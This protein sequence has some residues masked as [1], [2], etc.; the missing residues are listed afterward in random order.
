MPP[1]LREREAELS[2]VR[3]QL[4]AACA[5]NEKLDGAC[6]ELRGQLVLSHTQATDATQAVLVS[7]HAAEE[8]LVACQQDVE[9]LK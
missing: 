4:R 5:E 1:Q 7:R 2:S 3:M 8:R 6:A 9:V